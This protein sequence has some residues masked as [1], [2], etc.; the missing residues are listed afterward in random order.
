MSISELSTEHIFIFA[1]MLCMVWVV[2]SDAVHYIIPNSLNALII[3]LY[4][5]AAI[6]LPIPTWLSAFG[7]AGLMLVVGLG[8]FSLG[9]MGGGDV[10]LLV[11]LS[12]WTGWGMATPQFIFLTGVSGGALVVVVLLLRRILPPILR[13]KNPERVMPRLLTRKEPVPYGIAIAVAFAWLL[14]T[15]RVAG[16]AIT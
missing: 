10:K 16:L 4:I 14:M 13:R 6:V 3:V 8:F 1:L 5:L 9:L 15:G 12:L 11:A 2:V 7:A